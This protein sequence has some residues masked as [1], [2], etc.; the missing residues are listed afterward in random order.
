MARKTQKINFETSIA[1]LERLVE[2]MENG[3][4]TLEESLKQ[5]EH[6]ISLARTCQQALRDAEQRVLQLTKDEN[7]DENLSPFTPTDDD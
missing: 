3:E 1:A 4:F 2:K 5:F 6:G 7:G